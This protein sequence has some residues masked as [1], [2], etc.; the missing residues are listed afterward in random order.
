LA[1][2]TISSKRLPP[3]GN[4]TCCLPRG[5]PRRRPS[6]LSTSQIRRLV[7][8][9]QGS[10]DRT[11]QHFYRKEVCRHGRAEFPH[12]VSQQRRIE[13]LP[14]GL[15]PL[16]AYLRMHRGHRWGM[17]FLDSLPFPVC[18]HRRIY[19]HPVFAGFAQRGK[20]SVDGFYGLSG[21]L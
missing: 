4:R 21:T 16:S 1:I 6:R 13:G 5:R 10:D 3:L 12:L 11:F 8:A 9:F 17:A 15:A 20:S 14:S 7:I 2:W 18:H 19:S